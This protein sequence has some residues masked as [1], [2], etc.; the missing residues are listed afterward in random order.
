[1]LMMILKLTGKRR[2]SNDYIISILLYIILHIISIQ[3]RGINY[4][5]IIF[6]NFCEICT[7]GIT[8]RYQFSYER[9]NFP[10]R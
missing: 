3:E 2:H 4:A 5:L 7:F 10:Y 6:Y 8:M 1:M 9:E